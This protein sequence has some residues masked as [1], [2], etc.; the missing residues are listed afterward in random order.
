ME[1][2]MKEI[3]VKSSLDGSMQPSLFYAASGKDRPLLVGLHTWSFDRFNQVE[4][5]LP[6]AVA[7]DFNLLLPEFRGPNLPKNPICKE[8]CGSPLAIAD[9]FDAIEYVK[10][11]YG[12]DENNVFLL[13]TSGGGHMA[14]LCGAR[15]P[16]YFKA[17][18]A[19]VP[20]C[21]LVR[22]WGENKDYA[23]LIEACCD[24]EEDMLRRSPIFYAGA[25]G[26]ANLKIFHGKFDHGVSYLQSFDL[27]RAIMA[28]KPDAR[29]FLDIF[30][31]G[32]HMD[33]EVAMS[34]LLSQ[35]TK[36][37]LTAVTG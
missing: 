24:G 11:N 12:V 6:H 3:L 7:N 27:Y 19:F 13:G 4:N 25:L 26:E 32:H 14:L 20:V 1:N 15:S 21:D 2:N 18:G 28:A 34:W 29:V 35:Y 16:K 37:E 17:I 8:A 9:V 10:E 33:M 30:D 36:K 5:M 31:G 23:P 22:W